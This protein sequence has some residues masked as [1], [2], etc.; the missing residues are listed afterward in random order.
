[1]HIPSFWGEV[2]LADQYDHSASSIFPT[3]FHPPPPDPPP[4]RDH[5]DTSDS[6]KRNSHN[7]KV[8]AKLILSS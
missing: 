4:L 3:H 8:E 1:M 7:S 6:K 2:W 5:F